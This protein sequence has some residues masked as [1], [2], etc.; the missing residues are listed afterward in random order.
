MD[1]ITASRDDETAY[2]GFFEYEALVGLMDLITAY[3]D[4]ETAYIGFLC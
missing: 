1:L 3:P 2:I 4:D